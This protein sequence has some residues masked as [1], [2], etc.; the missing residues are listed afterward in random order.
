MTSLFLLDM[1]PSTALPGYSEDRP[2]RKES[3]EDVFDSEKTDCA[4][5]GKGKTTVLGGTEL[6][7]E[8]I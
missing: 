5:G 8:V 2:Q 7:T 3:T 1:S 6:P 4:S